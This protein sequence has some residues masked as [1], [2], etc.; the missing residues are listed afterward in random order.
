MAET[1]TMESLTSRIQ[2]LTAIASRAQLFSRLGQQ[3]GGARDIY[4]ALGYPLEIKYE[5]YAARYSRQD[6]A[7][8]VINRPVNATWRGGVGIIEPDTKKEVTSLEKD[9]KSLN[10]SLKLDSVFRSLDKVTSVGKY[11]VLMLGLDDVSN[12]EGFK[13]PVNTTGDRKLLYVRPFGEGA[14]EIKEWES[15][16][17][18]ERFGLP[19]IYQLTLQTSSNRSSG[20]TD[21]TVDVHYSRLIHVAFNTLQSEL[22][23][24]PALRDIFNRLIDLEKIVGG[25]A[26]MYW[27]GARPGYQAKVDEDFQLTPDMKE[28]LQDQIDEYEHNLRRILANE[29]IEFKSL[30]TQVS[31]PK[32]HVD[33]QVSMISAATGIPKRILTG[34]E[35]GELASSED[36]DSWFDLI[37]SRRDDQAENAIVRPFVDICIE[38]KI[39]P[40]PKD[41][42]QG[43]SLVWSDLWAP[44]EKQKVEIGKERATAIKDYTTNP[45]AMVIVPPKAFNKFVLGLDE[46]QLDEIDVFRGEDLAEEAADFE[47]LE[48]DDDAE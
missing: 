47:G 41:E 1:P 15:D 12:Q 37:D 35:R 20:V 8:A 11:G 16:T 31:D 28:D 22:E 42:E 10:K 21:G 48:D 40:G 34:S 32:S 26:E 6:M 46:D 38:Y 19:L 18:S 5:D 25:S 39:L 33:V 4:Q 30:E 9:W 7:S 2:V 23:G 43:Y 17:T 24:T 45:V 29:G 44:S 3:Y 36:R 14:A 13:Q 27:R